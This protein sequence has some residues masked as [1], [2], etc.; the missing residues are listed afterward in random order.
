M[1]TPK[2]SGQAFSIY[3]YDEE[4]YKVY[5]KL[6]LLPIDG[7][8]ANGYA[9]E[10]C[11]GWDWVKNTDDTDAGVGVLLKYSQFKPT[12]RV[13]ENSH[14]RSSLKTYADATFTMIKGVDYYI[15]CNP[16][17]PYD[18]GSS[19]NPATGISTP[20]PTSFT[21]NTTKT[22]IEDLGAASTADLNLSFSK[23]EFDPNNLATGYFSLYT[24]MSTSTLN[25]GEYIS[26]VVE[27]N[28]PD[29]NVDPTIGDT[30]HLIKVFQA[31]F[32]G[33]LSFQKALDPSHPH[34]TTSVVFDSAYPANGQR[35]FGYII[36]EVKPTG[37]RELPEY[38]NYTM[39]IR[40]YITVSGMGN[41][42]VYS[43]DQLQAVSTNSRIPLASLFTPRKDTQER[44]L[45]ESYRLEHSLK[46][47][48]KNDDPDLTYQYGNHQT[49][50]GGAPSVG[51]DELRSNLIG[52]GIPHFG[53]G[54][55]GG[56]IAFPV[57]DELSIGSVGYSPNFYNYDPTLYAFHG[58][59][60][61]LRN[62]L[63]MRRISIT[64]PP[65]ANDWLE[66]QVS[67][68]PNMTRNHL[69]GSKYGTPPRGVLVYP[70]QDFDGNTTQYEGYNLSNSGGSP[71]NP[72]IDSES[73]Y[74]LPN[75]NAGLSGVANAVDHMSGN[76]GNF[77]TW[78][79][80]DAA[81][82]G[83]SQEPV[84]RHA[85]PN[86]TGTATND[87]PEVGYLRAFDLNFGKSVERSPHL[88]YWNIDWTETT[89]KGDKVDRLSSSATPQGLIQ[90][91]EWERAK[92]NDNG[93]V[94]F[95]P[96]KLRLV[97]V[98]WDMISYID[99]QFP[100]TRR[101]GMV[102]NID[103]KKYLM[104][105]RVMRVFVKVP[106]LTTWLDVG[107]MNGEVGES[108][109]QYAGDP[110][111]TFGGMNEEGATSDKTHRSIDGAGCC[112][113][114]KETYLAEEGL[115]ALDLDLDVGFVP[116]FHSTGNIDPHTSLTISSQDTFLGQEKLIYAINS[117]KIYNSGRSGDFAWGKGGA[118][119]PILV[120][121]ILGNPEFPKYEVHPNNS[122]ALVVRDDLP[123]T[124]TLIADIYGGGGTD[125]IYDIWPAP[126]KSYRGHSYP[127]D[128]RAP[129]WA[130][131]GLM[132]IE[133]LRPDGSN[134]DRDKVIERPEFTNLSLFGSKTAAN[135][136]VSQD[137][138]TLYMLYRQ[139]SLSGSGYLRD[140]DALTSSIKT[141]KQSFT[142]DN[143]MVDYPNVDFD[144]TYT[145]SKKGEG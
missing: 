72:L 50:G 83:V 145:L 90:S 123:N 128:D 12:Y 58:Y 107:V 17:I 21:T 110:T 105:K 71:I 92:K 84:L 94:T 49:L 44:F 76:Y 10:L 65:S 14:T 73:G 30:V 80:D 103:N 27:A 31:M 45:D 86:Y 20:N 137:D 69:S 57:R 67:G 32:G 23:S 96:I 126:N 77:Q 46:N 127:P 88:P 121:V 19:I 51:N 60:G 35:H 59:A 3:R 74:F 6:D 79:D 93:S 87:S 34:P 5:Q 52:P 9:L 53:S 115:V 28:T 48:F 113:S 118:E 116:S 29:A 82:A 41:D 97:G 40:G 111:G 117:P 131:R 101:D 135:N 66:A 54:W 124:T 114:Y 62:S 122:S 61:Y 109:V 106:G 42:S 63:H 78:I 8:E 16:S 39:D 129:T 38:G 100:S 4:G 136:S 47:L 55:N 143:D 81:G 33:S 64:N 102:Y 108:Y 144:S 104:R 22:A 112:V 85:Q 68:F 1:Y 95:T 70:Y 11:S 125:E 37:R 99:P 15:E 139:S 43:E 134:Y 133:V 13:V 120:K 25:H 36:H 138:R 56:Y 75:S 26:R 7:V 130:R 24:S 2:S 142:F 141:N 119:A 98:D 132:G 18:W 89:T 140:S 91:G